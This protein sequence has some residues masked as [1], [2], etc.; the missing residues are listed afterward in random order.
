MGL[1]DDTVLPEGGWECIQE[2]VAAEWRF[3]RIAVHQGSEVGLGE[4][5]IFLAKGIA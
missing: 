1:K 3:G 5:R 4:W 2:E